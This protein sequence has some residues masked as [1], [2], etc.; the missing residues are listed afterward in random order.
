MKTLFFGAG[1]IGSVYAHL[2]VQTGGDVTVLDRGAR[3]DWL[4]NNGLV[5]VNEMTG[6]RQSSRVDVVNE[7]RPEDD[8]ELAIV[9]IRKNKLGPA[10]ETLAA[11]PGIKTILFMG[12]NALGFDMY[13]KHLPREKLLMGFPGVGGG[14]ID[15]IV[16]YADREKPKGQPRA[17][18]I[19]EIDGQT[20]ERTE[21]VK[22]L[23]QS[24][25]VPVD[26]TP[27][28]DGW[29]KYHVVLV[30]PL[31]CALYKHGCDAAQA[32]KD[33]EAH[34]AMVRAVKEGGRVLRALG[35]RKRQ[36]FKINL[37]YWLPE[38]I[39][40]KGVKALLESKF[41]SVAFALHAQAAR[42]EFEEMVHE[43]QQLADATSVET[44][45]VD[46]LRSY[47]G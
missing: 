7:L 15:Q 36:P 34:R 29:L 16:H 42:D 10:F 19:G 12:N 41:A 25:G 3:Y 27:D 32:A 9:S 26:I 46:T 30:S 6:E 39:M 17:I 43:F 11:C 4:K 5:L 28:I 40:M 38:F 47:I 8:Y 24:A 45:N 33:T 31:A 21:A 20:R 13:L 23:F 14:N 35:F 1:P 37:F 18:T 2:L 44:P 22:A